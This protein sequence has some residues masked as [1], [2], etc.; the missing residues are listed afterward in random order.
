MAGSDFSVT[1]RENSLPSFDLIPS[2]AIIW[3][4]YKPAQKHSLEQPD[5]TSLQAA[6]RQLERNAAH[7]ADVVE[8]TLDGR[9]IANAWNQDHIAGPVGAPLAHAISTRAE[10]IG[11]GEDRKGQLAVAGAM[12]GVIALL[13]PRTT[14][15]L[16][17]LTFLGHDIADVQHAWTKS[18]ARD[19]A[20]FQ[21]FQAADDFDPHADIAHLMPAV[22][23]AKG[24]FWDTVHFDARTNFVLAVRE[25]ERAGIQVIPTEGVVTPHCRTASSLV[26]DLL[27]LPAAQSQFQILQ[28]AY[29]SPCLNEVLVLPTS[30]LPAPQMSGWSTIPGR[31]D[32]DPLELVM[33]PILSESF[34]VSV[35]SGFSADG[36]PTGIMFVGPTERAAHVLALA[37]WYCQKTRWPTVAHLG[38]RT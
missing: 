11:L 6:L 2:R 18:L 19:S 7:I 4:R 28:G 22:R 13:A 1:S 12:S 20:M 23:M 5:D 3:L 31:F 24:R 33:V 27:S 35:P 9:L 30:S 10:T 34:A 14:P 36:L 15:M 8:E 29:Q 38:A 25:F 21:L 26:R 32:P 16:G 17:R 37:N